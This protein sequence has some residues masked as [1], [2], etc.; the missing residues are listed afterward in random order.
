MAEKVN[1]I[2][3]QGATFS[4]RFQVY[5]ENDE[6]IDFTNYSG[7]SQFRKSHSSS[8]GYAF[9][10]SLSNNGIITLLMDSTTT[11]VIPDG[12]Y[13]YDVEVNDNLTNNKMRI[14]EGIITVT[15]QATKV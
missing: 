6:L 9:I 4:V 10:V 7:N 1:L 11:N 5:D 3:D 14:V 13:V 15:P 8:T 2:I 12:R